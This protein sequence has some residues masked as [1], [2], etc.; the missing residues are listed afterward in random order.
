VW[1][2][3]GDYWNLGLGA[4]IGLYF[5]ESEGAFH[6]KVVENDKFISVDMT[7]THVGAVSNPVFDCRLQKPIGHL[8]F[9]KWNKEAPRPAR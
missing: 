1:C 3:K 9:P 8:Y 2:W 6:W 5:A 4:E 7:L